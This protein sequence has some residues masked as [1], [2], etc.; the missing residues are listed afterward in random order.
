MQVPGCPAEVILLV[1]LNVIDRICN[2]TMTSVL[3]QIP[4]GLECSVWVGNAQL[5]Y[6]VFSMYGALYILKY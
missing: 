1:K 2:G 4:E 3:H 6:I 5:F